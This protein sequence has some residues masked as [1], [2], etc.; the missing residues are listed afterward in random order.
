MRD[1]AVF[2]PETIE[3]LRSSLD[4]AWMNLTPTQQAS[5]SKSA[6][7]A[8]ILEAAA[9]GERD[10]GLLQLHATLPVGAPAQPEVPMARGGDNKD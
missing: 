5:T 7:A 9:E 1:G 10:P 4:A 2:D 3:L 6:L 8:R